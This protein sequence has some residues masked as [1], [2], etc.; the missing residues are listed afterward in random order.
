MDLVSGAKRV[1]VAM[2]HTA[3]GA[4]KI[5]KACSLPLTSIRPVSLI[6]TDLAVIQPTEQG[7]VLTEHADH[8]AV[9]EILAQTDANLMVATNI[10]PMG[11]LG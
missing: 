10:R 4:A 1:I 11:L 3:K 9:D 5:V 7:L 2:K 8:V 6:V